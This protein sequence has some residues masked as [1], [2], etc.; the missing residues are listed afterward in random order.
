MT[1]SNNQLTRL[2]RPPHHRAELVYAVASF[3]VAL[4]LAALWPT[5]TTW[6]EGQPA[7]RQ[8]GLWPLIA[9]V[10]MLVFGLGELMASVWR[11]RYNSTGSA[12][13]EVLHWVRASEYLVW[14]LLYVFLVPLGGYLPVTLVFC[15]TLAWRLGYRGRML[16][17]AALAAVV[18]VVIFKAFLSVRIP[19][20]DL[21]EI[22]PQTIRNFLVLYL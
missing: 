7:G 4:G 5:Q 16:Y 8:P 19:G 9:I 20:G 22:F 18:I 2:I 10:G 15:V 11:N 3:S 21:Y 6:F 13:A 14:F 12:V 1:D 17:A